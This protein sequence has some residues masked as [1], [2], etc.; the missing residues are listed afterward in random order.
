MGLAATDSTAARRA[1]RHGRRKLAGRPIAQ[2]GE[3]AHHL[4]EGGIDVVGELDFRHRLEPVHAHTDRRRDNAALRDR[5]IEHAMLTV[6][7]L[8]PIGDTEYTTEITNILA[9]HHDPG[10]ALQ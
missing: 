4:V 6:L 2:P 9:E 8:Q 3:L 1:N 5:S 10:V 7:T